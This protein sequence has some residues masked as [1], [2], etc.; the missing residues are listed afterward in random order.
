MFEEVVQLFTENGSF[1]R[2]GQEIVGRSAIRETYRGRPS[3]TTMHMQSNFHLLDA[4]G[5]RATASVY[6]LVVGLPTKSDS[7]LP[8]D[9]QEAIRILEFH[10]EYYREAEGWRFSRRDARPVFQSLN[11]PY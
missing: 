9:S 11:W 8:F 6:N 2:N 3:A 5:E 4:D 10:D 7:V 1:I